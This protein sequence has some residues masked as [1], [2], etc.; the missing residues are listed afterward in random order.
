MLN[1][2]STTSLAPR[3]ALILRPWTAVM[4]ITGTV[5]NAG[6]SRSARRNCWPFIPGIIRSSRIASGR[7]AWTRSSAVSPS[8][9]RSTT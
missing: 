3:V 2:F 1:G 9:A 7:V 6:S 5:A 4:I 8:T